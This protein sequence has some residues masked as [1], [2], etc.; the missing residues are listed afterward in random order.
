MSDFIH[1]R[2]F[3]HQGDI[4]VVNCSHRCN[5]RIM[6]AALSTVVATIITAASTRGYRP[7]SPS[8]TM[9]TGTRPSIWV[10][11]KLTSATA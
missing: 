6:D 10:A 4:V 7:A 3:L 8:L 2:E 11:A 9:A 5:V 1:S